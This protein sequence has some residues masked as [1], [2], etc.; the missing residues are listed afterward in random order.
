MTKNKPASKTR[1]NYGSYLDEGS[2]RENLSYDDHLKKKYVR[3]HLTIFIPTLAVHN[4]FITGSN[5]FHLS[6]IKYGDK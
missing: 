6:N 3:I 2:D 1:T 5:V 4:S